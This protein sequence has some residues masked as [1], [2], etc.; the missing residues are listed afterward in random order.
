MVDVATFDGD[1]VVKAGEVKHAISRQK[2][3]KENHVV[4]VLL[5][6]LANLRPVTIK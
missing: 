1:E 6:L 2:K 4:I 3:V 5:L